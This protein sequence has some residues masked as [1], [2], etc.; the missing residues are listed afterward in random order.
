[1]VCGVCYETAC[2]VYYET[3]CVVYYET[4]CA[5]FYES[6]R[7]AIRQ[8]RCQYC[9][10][11]K[12]PLILESLDEQIHREG[13][14]EGTDGLAKWRWLEYAATT[15]RECT[16]HRQAAG[17]TTVDGPRQVTLTTVTEIKL[18]VSCITTKDTVPPEQA[19]RQIIKGLHA[20]SFD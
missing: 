18:A 17:F 16:R 14:A 12:A 9:A 3:A 7:G 10:H 20:A 5:V 19:E 4:A 15:K 13:I 8:E 11:C 1:L 2:V 6:A